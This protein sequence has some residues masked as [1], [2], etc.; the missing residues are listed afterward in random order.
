ML[1]CVSILKILKLNPTKISLKQGGNNLQF[2]KLVQ[3]SRLF[4][5]HFSCLLLNKGFD[6]IIIFYFLCK[7]G[8]NNQSGK[9][10]HMGLTAGCSQMIFDYFELAK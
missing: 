4:Q 8:F 2:Q 5:K 3:M 7:F 1:S 9:I 10:Q 6:N